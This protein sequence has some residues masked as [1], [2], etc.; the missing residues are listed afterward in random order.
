MVNMTSKL[1]WLFGKNSDL[2]PMNMPNGMLFWAARRITGLV[3]AVYIFAHLLVLSNLWG[4][5]GSWEGAMTLMESPL[6]VFLD[7]LLLGAVIV[8]V[9]TGAAVI[10]FDMGK[11]VRSHKKVYWILTVIGVVL[12]IFAVYGAYMLIVNTGG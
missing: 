6:F 9:V 5:T 4:G 10:M 12:F 1:K 8:H 2:Y 7:L 3:L 11:G